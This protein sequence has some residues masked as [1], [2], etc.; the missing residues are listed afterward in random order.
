MTRRVCVFADESGNFDFSRS[1][2]ASRY[3]ILVTVSAPDFSVGQALLDLRR[4]LAWRGVGLDTEFHA[5]TDT[6]QVR[7]EV[8]RALA[9]HQFR[10][11]ATILQKTKAQPS[12]RGTDERFYQMA[13][14]LHMKHLAPR[15]ANPSDELFIVGAS[16]GTRKRRGAFH[17]AVAD[18]ISQVSPTTQF[19][20]AAWNA[21]SDPCL[22]VV[23][24]CAWAIQRK[25][26]RGDARSH[27]LIAEK[28]GSEFDAFRTGMVEYY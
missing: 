14:Y 13:W 9:P 27:A 21:A 19:R 7:D 12:I 11:D 6:Q 17:R 4:D 22:Q 26:E 24:Y 28:I 8:F 3:F 15:I 18:V 25:W 2:G 1:A 5:T 10:V 23:D 16:V 20:V